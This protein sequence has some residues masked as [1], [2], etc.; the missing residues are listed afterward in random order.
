[1]D[2]PINPKKEA[3]DMSVL[4]GSVIVSRTKSIKINLI[5]DS[6]NMRYWLLIHVK[7]IKLSSWLNLLIK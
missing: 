3:A 2:T 6:I 5:I 7:N 4:P 1:M